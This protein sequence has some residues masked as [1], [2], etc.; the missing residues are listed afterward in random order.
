MYRNLFLAVLALLTAFAH[1]H[2]TFTTLYVD[3]ENQGDGVCV[4]MNRNPSKATFPIEPLSSK[5]V[6]CGYDGE[7]AVARVCPAKASSTLT[8][9]FRE[10]ADGSQPGSIDESHKGPCAVYMKKVDDATADNNAAGD[11]WFKIWEADYDATAGKWCTEKMIENNGHISVQIPADIEGGYYLVRPELLALHAAQ[12]S[13][14]DPQFY[15]G[16]A[17]VFVQSTGTAKPPTVSIGEGTY[18][19]SLPGMTYNIYK[20]PLSLPYPMYGPPVYKAGAAS[21]NTAPAN[22]A[23]ATAASANPAPANTASANAGSANSASADTAPVNPAPADTALVNTAS[24]DTGSE[25]PAPVPANVCKSKNKKKRTTKKKRAMLV[26]TKGLKPEGCILVRDNWCGFEVPSYTDEDS[27]WAS[28]KNC[29]DQADVCW[30]TALPTGS[31][32]CQIWSD[33]CTALGE[34]CS[35]KVFPG[36]PNAG[37][38]LTPRPASLV[39]S[40]K[41]FERG[42]R[43][44]CLGGAGNIVRESTKAMENEMRALGISEDDIATIL[45]TIYWGIN[46]N[47]RKAAFWLLTYILHYG[48]QH[49]VDMI[50]EETLPAFSPD[51]S[52]P[53]LDYLHDNCPHL[54]AMWNETIRLSAILCKGNRLMIPYQQLHFDESIFGVDY[55]VE[56]FR[57]ELFMQKG[58]NL[59]RS[60]NWRP[61]RGGTKQCPGR[62]VAKRFVLLFV[63]MLLR[64]FDVELVTRRIPAAEEG[65]PMLGIMSIKDGEDVLVRVRPR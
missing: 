16:C 20:T 37:Q 41:L 55:P 61:F 42:V 1:A 4:R 17:Q 5:D 45:V 21:V 36:P 52:I 24:D 6:A 3:G 40:I 53:D 39:G 10:Y 59:T 33:K 48:P 43:A 35:N 27:C 51:K 25:K 28:A 18:D 14:P 56:E 57:H 8:F 38:D 62:Y 47:T 9:E 19:L 32:H 31:A 34:S 63:A 26:Q 2:T 54:D 7:K 44:S 50:R 22:T 46:A 64:R 30:N 29:W 13:P 12:D 11:G 49:Y 58:R 15:V 65:K 60:D 23:P